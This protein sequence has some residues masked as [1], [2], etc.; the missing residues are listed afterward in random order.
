MFYGK[1]KSNINKNFSFSRIML[2]CLFL[3]F[4]L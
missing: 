3:L 1:S 2:P 4:I